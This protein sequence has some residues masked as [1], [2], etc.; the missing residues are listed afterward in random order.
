MRFVNQKQ[1]AELLADDRAAVMVLKASDFDETGAWLQETERFVDFP[2]MVETVQV[3]VM[4]TEPPARSANGE[5]V[6]T[7]GPAPIGLSFRSKP[8]IDA[9]SG[10]I[11]VADLAA[12]FGGG[13]HARAA[14]AK[15]HGDLTDVVLQVKAAIENTFA[16]SQ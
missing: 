4:I 2:R 6:E 14:G 9:A 15:V 12:G 11:N 13:G 7:D 16:S 1:L 10:A 5:A 3:V 8:P